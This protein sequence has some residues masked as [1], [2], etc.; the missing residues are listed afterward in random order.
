MSSIEVLGCSLVLP[1]WQAMWFYCLK[2]IP[3]GFKEE[4]CE[5]SMNFWKNL[6]LANQKIFGTIREADWQGVVSV[7]CALSSV[8]FAQTCAVSHSSKIIHS[9][10]TCQELKFREKLMLGPSSGW[11]QTSQL[12]YVNNGGKM[13]QQKR[14]LLCRD[15]YFQKMKSVGHNKSYS[16]LIPASASILSR[17]P[18]TVGLVLLVSLQCPW[19]SAWWISKRVVPLHRLWATHSS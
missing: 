14:A 3:A 6:M 8:A 12:L 16:P 4:K 1:F 2:I 17:N 19:H 5:F 7:D 9:W 13:D 11:L 18:V 15:S 10:F